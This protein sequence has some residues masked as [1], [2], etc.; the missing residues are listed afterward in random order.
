MKKVINNFQ[1]FKN[2]LGKKGYKRF[3]I[4]AYVLMLLA[5]GGTSTV[6][7]AADDPLSVVLDYQSRVMIQAKE[8]MDS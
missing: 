7:L 2:G 4:F 6:V 5:I 3:K 1:K 8:Q